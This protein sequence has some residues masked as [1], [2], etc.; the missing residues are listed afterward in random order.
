MKKITLSSVTAGTMLAALALAPAK[1]EAQSASISATATVA[2]ALNVN[3]VRDLGFGTV[4]PGFNRTILA[5]DATSGHF[6]IVGGANAEVAV[7]FSS[8]PG[9]LTG[10]GADLA[11]SLTANHNV[12][13]AAGVG[14]GFV[15]AGGVTTR[16]DTSTG[17]L[18]VYMGGT[19]IVPAGQVAGLYSGTITLDA[20]YTGN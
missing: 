11:L 16:L 18:H 19:L 6:Q 5:T 8:L 10:P 3:N 17:E 15:P 1:A 7:S 2:T 12:T 14:T 20:A 13:D 9:V 4:I